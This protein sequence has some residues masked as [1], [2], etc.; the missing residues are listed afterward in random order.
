MEKT[1]KRPRDNLP[2]NDALS[3]PQA[4]AASGSQE[5]QLLTQLTA[6]EQTFK[7]DFSGYWGGRRNGWSPHA[8]IFSARVETS[9]ASGH[10]FM[11]DSQ[12]GSIRVLRGD[13][14]L[15]IEVWW[16]GRAPWG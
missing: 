10:C 9:G 16:K 15:M 5:L 11:C 12:T 2:P 3:D 7:A 14:V 6:P 1:A 8:L 13:V 4:A